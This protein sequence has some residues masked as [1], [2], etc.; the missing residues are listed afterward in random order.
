[1]NTV[2]EFFLTNSAAIAIVSAASGIITKLIIN[3]SLKKAQIEI[4]REGKKI[5]YEIQRKY[6]LTEIRIRHLLEIYPKLHDA[7][8]LAASPFTS[9]F[10]TILDQIDLIKGQGGEPTTSQI[11]QFIEVYFIDIFNEDRLNLKIEHVNELNNTLVSSSLFISEEVRE[12]VLEMKNEIMNL[13]RLVRHEIASGKVNDFNHEQL[14]NLLD[15]AA[16]SLSS[17]NQNKDHLAIKMNKELD[18]VFN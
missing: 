3:R 12:I 5:E 10:A 18:P 13:F 6:M 17:L 15:R 1:M 14:I 8:H 16:K 11:L 9:Y 2:F 4:D 7:V